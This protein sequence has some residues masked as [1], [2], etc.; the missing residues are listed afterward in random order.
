MIIL[1]I[2][3]QIEVP[4]LLDAVKDAGLKIWTFGTQNDDAGCVALQ[5][6]RGIDAVYRNNICALFRR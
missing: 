1:Y 5:H 4:L 3:D 6:R 2:D